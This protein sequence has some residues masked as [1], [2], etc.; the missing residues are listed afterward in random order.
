MGFFDKKNCTTINIKEFINEYIEGAVIP[1]DLLIELQE[2]QMQGI[3]SIQIP[4]SVVLEIKAKSNAYKYER[5]AMLKCTKL[6]NLGIHEE[7]LGNIDYAIQIYEDNLNSSFIAGHSFDRLMILYRK[8]KDYDNEIRVIN[9]ALDV[10]C[11]RYP[12][13]KD[14]YLKR[15]EKAKQLKNNSK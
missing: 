7:E 1:I 15:L 12:Q 8:K 11:K 13:L 2:K 9:K 10:L 3:T 4:T 6:N 5:E 14:K